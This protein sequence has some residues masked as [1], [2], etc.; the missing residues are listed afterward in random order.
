MAVLCGNLLENTDRRHVAD[1][2]RVEEVV[3]IVLVVGPAIVRRPDR[4]QRFGPNMGSGSVS[5]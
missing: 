5:L 3:E 4:C 1:L 2:Q